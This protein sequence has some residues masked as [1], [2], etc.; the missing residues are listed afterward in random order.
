MC[1]RAVSGRAV[2]VRSV[3][4]I[5]V[6]VLLALLRF[7]A[8]D[9]A[10]AQPESS[11]SGT[12]TDALGGR[13]AG[14]TVTLTGG[15]PA[16]STTN[17]NGEYVFARVAPGRYQV[18]A[19]AEGF[20]VASSRPLFIG[21]GDSVSADLSLQIG[22]LQQ[23]VVVT[24]H[25]IGVSQAQTAAPVTVIDAALLTSLDKPDL[26]E[27]FR[28]VPGSQVQQSGGRGGTSSMFVR[29]GSANFTKV[30]VD[31][32]AANDIGG[33]FDFSQIQTTGVDRV[34]ILRQSNSVMYGS[35][36]LAGVI[37]IETR[38]G[39]TRMPELNYTV[40]GGNLATL[41]NVLSAGGTYKRLDF[42]SEYSL[43]TTDN[44]VPNNQYRNGTYAG[45]FGLAA[46]S[47][48]DVSGTIRHVNGEYGSPNAPLLYGIPDDSTSTS[49]LTYVGIT[50]QTQWS[51]RWQSTVRFGSTGQ[52]SSYLNPTPTGEAYDPF[53]FGANYLGD[54]VT[55]RGANGYSA[56]GRAIL[57]FGGVYPSPFDSRTTRRQ[58]S[59]Q[60]T[61]RI[62]GDLHLSVGARYEQE[63]GFDDPDDDATATRNNG[64]IFAE[65]R[66]SLGRR[67]YVSA[68]VG[69]ERNAV[70]G[71][72]VTPRVSIANYLRDA[73]SGAIGET[74]VTF[75]AGSGIK[76]PSVFQQ[77]SSIFELVQ[78]LPAGARPS[79]DPIGPE[80]S[81][82]V[83]LGVEQAF[84]KSHVRVRAS[85]F[86]NRFED[87]I[88]FVSKSALPQVGIPAAT[89]QATPFGAYVNSS[90]FDANGLELSGEAALTRQ[91]RVTGTYTLL[92]AEVT[93]SFASSALSPAIN[94]AF[95]GIPI[96][97]FSP[98]IGSRPF[99]R[100]THSGSLMAAY[101]RGPADVTLSAYFSGKRDGS[102]FLSD[103]DF[104]NSLLLPNKDLEPAYQKVDLAGSYRFHRQVRAFVSVENLLDKE[105]QQSFG[106]P[107]LPRTAR[108]GMTL[109]LG[110]DR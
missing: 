90:S 35:D 17:A 86:M 81:R 9:T 5:A 50:A 107:A 49:N 54:R 59:G 95:P 61:V 51:D 106:Y 43:F 15:T 11:V 70:F 34:E 58:L 100:P 36:A 3:R 67:T 25:A 53:G 80:R 96:G 56:T 6:I 66:G 84:A 99:R 10:W 76:A 65:G 78:S 101:S 55:I 4:G 57:D 63:K 94:P 31:G 28:L 23:A 19:R 83:D 68:G 48:T 27:A 21:S 91:V 39:R 74:K 7:V 97:A 71:S 22:P 14:A 33:A 98:L 77:Q 79:V 110:G 30:L 38:R 24:A 13:I 52:T 93:K 69:Y 37:N 102:T 8:A 41:R 62:A 1:E 105:Y 89:A 72:A 82:S 85:V 87:I 32:I 103:A 46:G 92:D 73:S 16:E 29:G 2:P 42:F 108:V 26:Q 75:N 12:V 64:G 20:E 104:G 40:D 88:E 47:N 109:L 60:S 44:S 45:R 18:I